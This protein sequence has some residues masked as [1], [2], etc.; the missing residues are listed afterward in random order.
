[1]N[2]NSAHEPRAPDRNDTNH[3]AH[4][5]IIQFKC[6]YLLAVNKFLNGIGICLFGNL[7]PIYSA[8]TRRGVVKRNEVSNWS[9]CGCLCCLTGK[10]KYQCGHP[11]HIF[12]VKSFLL[13]F[14]FVSNGWS[15]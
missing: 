9:N 1:M 8:F 6:C 15:K 13:L 14:D 11:H 12:Y 4:K 3:D 2:E 5:Y 7:V 10:I